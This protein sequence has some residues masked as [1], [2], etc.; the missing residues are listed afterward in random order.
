MS[1][2]GLGMIT[3]SI[4]VGIVIITAAIVHKILCVN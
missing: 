3:W 4:V 2:F 1:D